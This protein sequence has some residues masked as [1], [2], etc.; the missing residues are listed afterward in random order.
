[1]AGA[2]RVPT[3]SR[4]ASARRLMLAAAFAIFA[5]TWQ[6][7]GVEAG[8]SSSGST[9]A[10]GGKLDKPASI[11]RDAR[12]Q[13]DQAEVLAMYMHHRHITPVHFLTVLL[14][15]QGDYSITKSLQECGGNLYELKKALSNVLIKLPTSS[16]VYIVD[17]VESTAQLKRVALRALNIAQK[18]KKQTIGMEHLI[19]SLFEER[20]LRTMLEQVGCNVKVFLEHST[21]MYETKFKEDVANRSKKKQG[22]T[23][24]SST[25]ES[26][27][28]NSDE[29]FVKSFGVDMTQLAADG[30]LEPV[31]GRNKEIK[32]V[33]TV[34]SRK[35]KGNPC[36][37]GEPGVGKTAVVEGLAQRLI[38]GMVPKSLENK[39]LF[40]VD[41]GA[42]I[43]GATYRGEFEKRM[44]ALLRYAVG[45]EGRV[46]LF[47]DE[48]HMLMGAGKSDGTV[49]A[50]NL[51]KPPMARGEIRLVGATTQEEYKIIERDAA[52]ERRLKPILVEEPTTDR[53]I[54][55]LRKLKEKFERHHEMTISDEAI[56]SAV[57]L[58]HKYIKNRKLPDKAIDLL[59]EAA[60]TKRVKW[61]LRT[62]DDDEMASEKKQKEKLEE[63]HRKVEE[64]DKK[65]IEG[66]H[67][68]AGT[69]EELKLLE[70]EIEQ[71]ALEEEQE[72]VLTADDVA[73][74]I[75]SWTGIPVAKLTDDEKGKILRLSDLLHSRV[76]GQEDAVKA[77]ADAM[78]RARAGLSREGMPVGSFLFLGPTGVGKTELAKALAA[79]MFHSE[80]NLIRIDMSEFSE[81]HSVSRL[82]GSPPGYVGHEAGGQ[83]T[84]AVRRRPHSVV[85][86]DEIEKGHQQI[87]NIMLQMLDE[88]RLTDGKGLLVDFTNC[89][90]ILTSNVGAQYIIS[91]YEQGEKDSRSALATFDPK[92]GSLEQF[93]EAT[94]AA[95][96][97]AESDDAASAKTDKKGAVLDKNK[98][99]G[100]WKKEARRK[101]LS[102]IAGSGLLKPEV[103][104]RFS[105]VII[106]EPMKPSDVRKILSI[107][108][109]D[110]KE[111]L[112]R[113]GIEL[114]IDG[115]AEEF[116]VQR[117]YTHKFGA[118]PLKRFVDNQIGAK[119]APWILSGYLQPGMRVT[120][121]ASKRNK[122]TLEAHVCKVVMGKCD[123]TTRKARVL[124]SV[125]KK[126]DSSPDDPGR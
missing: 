84:E 57:M 23:S 97:A 101:I 91:A 90:I 125:A 111:A 82:I 104:N 114:V 5:L 1:M 94:K 59:D 92:S 118:R 71:E 72:L 8:T 86:F 56:V 6:T 89:V 43:A 98:K 70:K 66:Q 17:E 121:V 61:D 26:T 107:Q 60:A 9:P 29:E 34:L 65:R 13:L 95:Q 115:S 69:E 108:S 11:S 106:F 36:L 81:A 33:I 52:M 47:I 41:L 2:R 18:D 12:E 15:V 35:G 27:P 88:G 126:D 124:A 74:V 80:K 54:Y 119:M 20:N 4:A 21:A 83:L 78:V 62:V 112:A 120:V 39:I 67:H 40:A 63:E 75:S 100:N 93:A 96:V 30:K 46:I 110:L 48:I 32:E 105:G 109:K 44:K 28:E 10:P 116:I 99:S 123:R 113:K 7:R 77:V 50:A 14:E 64:Q 58:S 16:E 38:E 68:G 25:S 49:D 45:Q 24:A 73:V 79:E 51:L 42:L 31:V 37:I 85:L 22:S 76:I 3:G 55:I 53:A 122:N 87:L 19:L 117:S 102:E 103:V